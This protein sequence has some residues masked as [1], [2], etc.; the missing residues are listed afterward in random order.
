MREPTLQKKYEGKT[1]IAYHTGY[2][3]FDV[4]DIEH[5]IE[6]VLVTREFNPNKKNQYTYRRNTVKY[7]IGKGRP[8]II[9]HNRVCYMSD[10]LR[11]DL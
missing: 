6:T 11:Y 8:F 2:P 10:M 4:M 9:K 1:P 5:G 3:A 7:T